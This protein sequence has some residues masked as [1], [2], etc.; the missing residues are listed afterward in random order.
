MSASCRRRWKGPWPDPGRRH[1]SE[2]VERVARAIM[3]AHQSGKSLRPAAFSGVPSY[4][5][6][7][8]RAAILAMR[9]PTGT[10]V[11]A[12]P[13][14]NRDGGVFEGWRAMIDAALSQK[15]DGKEG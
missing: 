11:L 15:Q 2:M 9:E 13:A 14:W 5:E 3:V 8:A 1:H 10:M 4:Y 7:M 6:D 12:N